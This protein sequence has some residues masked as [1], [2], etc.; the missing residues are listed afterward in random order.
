MHTIIN[1]GE[2]K[3]EGLA[4]CWSESL[5]WKLSIRAYFKS[6]R[7]YKA[8]SSPRDTSRRSTVDEKHFW[9]ATTENSQQTLNQTHSTGSCT[10]CKVNGS[11]PT[12]KSLKFH[13]Y[14][15]S[16]ICSSFLASYR[17][18]QVHCVQPLDPRHWTLIFIICHTYCIFHHWICKCVMYPPMYCSLYVVTIECSGRSEVQNY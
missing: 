3:E 13:D 12:P 11:L 8:N 18:S 9:S 4:F 5:D 2:K 14:F 17:R 7:R 6:S 10:F 1:R 16:L 15:V